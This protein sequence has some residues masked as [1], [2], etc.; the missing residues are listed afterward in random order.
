MRKSIFLSVFLLSVMLAF[1]F[2]SCISDPHPAGGE[3]PAFDGQNQET[4]VT[5][6]VVST[7]STAGIDRLMAQVEEARKRAMD[8]ESPA[9]FPSDWEDVESRYADAGNAQKP[10]TESEVRQA[11]ASLSAILD[12]YN[13]LFKKTIPLYAQAREDEIMAAR[14]DLIGTGLTSSFPEYLERAD[15]IA[16]TALDQ[17]EA[18]DY[19]ASRDTAAKALWEYE[20]LFE[21]A[22]IYLKRQEII[23]RGFYEYDPVNFDKADE[24]ALEAVDNYEAGDQEAAADNAQEAMLRYNVLLTNGW[25]SYSADRRSSASLEREMALA[26]KVNVAVRDAFREA[27]A[28]YSQAVDS[29]R[30]EK[31]EEAAI[32]FTDSEALFA[33]ARQ[34]TEGKRR[35]AIET[36]RIAEETIEGSSEAAAEA[37][38]IIEGGSR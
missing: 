34:D 16:L 6:P 33:V 15:K 20:A 24:V 14:Y 37:E 36:I 5:P 19:Y 12:T 26:D 31:F 7:V 30:A 29:F 35:R 8:F 2:V 9:Y 28:I 11:T 10:T 23:D 4:P 3:V 18:E 21:G 13:E 17:Y 22:M 32:L 1:V 25:T 38:R 27:D